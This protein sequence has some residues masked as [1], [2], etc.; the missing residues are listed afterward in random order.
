MLAQ[1]VL[2]LLS[3]VFFQLCG[4]HLTLVV[5]RFQPFFVLFKRDLELNGKICGCDGVE[6]EL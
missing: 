3:H 2:D 1:Q 5:L 6:V 4:C